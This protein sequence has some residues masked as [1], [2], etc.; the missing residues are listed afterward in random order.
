MQLNDVCTSAK[1]LLT[2][3]DLCLH[4]AE[5]AAKTHQLPV[6]LCESVL[7]SLVTSDSL[8]ELC[9]TQDSNQCLP[10]RVADGETGLCL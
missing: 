3:T 2:T 10:L 1:V 7:L 9:F 6:L 8:S 5:R 4:V